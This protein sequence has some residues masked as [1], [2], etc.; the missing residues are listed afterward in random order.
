[1]R[2]PSAIQ[3]A[4]YLAPFIGSY[5]CKPEAPAATTAHGEADDDHR[6]CDRQ[7]VRS[8][9]QAVVGALDVRRGPG[10]EER[11]RTR[12]LREVER[13]DRAVR[14]GVPLGQRSQAPV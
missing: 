14:L 6:D 12:P 3:G 10:R 7:S 2:G 13:T 5:C 9:E 4:S 11:W 8:V 1:M